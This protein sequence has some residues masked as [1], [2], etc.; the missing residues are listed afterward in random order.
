MKLKYLWVIALLATTIFISLNA[1]RLSEFKRLSDAKRKW[2]SHEFLDYQFNMSGPMAMG[3][4]PHS[5]D[6]IVKNGQ[7]D[8]VAWQ[9]ETYGYLDQ[10]LLRDWAFKHAMTIPEAFAI[11]G[12]HILTAD[13]IITIEY[14]PLYGFPTQVQ[15]DPVKS[16]Y[17][18]E[19][20]LKIIDLQ[21]IR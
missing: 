20:H 2:Y 16:Y 3:L 17:D 21:L 14:N 12:K 15:L 11:V 6:V 1:R 8:S 10:E 18:E 5:L 19:I 4:P 7:V 9:Q 13:R